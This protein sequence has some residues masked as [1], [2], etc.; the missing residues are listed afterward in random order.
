[1]AG[2]M[3]KAGIWIKFPASAWPKELVAQLE[4]WEADRVSSAAA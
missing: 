2:A 3:P 4:I 1:M